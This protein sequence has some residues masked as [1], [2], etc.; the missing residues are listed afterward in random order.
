MFYEEFGEKT[1]EMEKWGD[2]G[3]DYVFQF[4]FSPHLHL[5]KNHSR[6][7]AKYTPLCYNYELKSNSSVRNMS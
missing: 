7:S 3:S 2:Q 6:Y 4:S 1:P 5:K